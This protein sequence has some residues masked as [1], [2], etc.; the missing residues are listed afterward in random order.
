VLTRAVRGVGGA[1]GGGVGE[2]VAAGA[3]AA[4]VA[5]TL[6]FLFGRRI[7]AAVG[8]LVRIA[9]AVERGD[10]AEPPRTGLTEVNAVAEQL[11]AAADFARAREQDAALG[12]R[13]A[14][15]MAEIA[16]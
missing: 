11:V 8:A 3:V 2:M 14:R 1:L 16:H 13:Q 7:A 5:A 15:A 10:R 9:Y 6:A 12:E 4:A